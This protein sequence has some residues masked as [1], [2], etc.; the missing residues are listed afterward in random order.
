[1]KCMMK[2]EIFLKKIV[3]EQFH[4]KGKDEIYMNYLYYRALTCAD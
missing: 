2:L 1:M 3:S 4:N